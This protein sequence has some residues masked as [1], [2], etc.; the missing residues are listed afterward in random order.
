M[1]TKLPWTGTSNTNSLTRSVVSRRD[2]T[3]GGL[4]SIAATTLSKPALAQQFPSQDVH[5]ICAFPAGSGADV[6][7][8]YMA[9]KMRPLIGRSILV[10]NKPGALG[11]ISTEYL[12]RSKPDGHTILI[13]GASGVAAAASIVKNPAFDVSKAIQLVGTI[14][15][16]PTM[17]A[18]HV[19]KPWKTVGEVTAAVKEKKEKATYATTNPV[20]KVM[21]AIYKKTL[22]LQSIE[23]NYRTAADTLNDL[24]NGAIDYML[25][26]N[27]FAMSQVRENRVRV[28]AVSTG[29]RLQ[30][31][32][33]IPTMAESGIPMD[34]T[35]Y[36][37]AMVPTGTPQPVMQQIN[38]WVNEV[39]ASD[40]TKKFLN[41]FASDPWVTTS[42]QGQ[43]YFLKD[44]ENWK[45]YVKIAE[46][47]QQG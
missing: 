46:I 28:L 11:N 13:H 1:T 16:Q 31:N 41:S 19:S 8:R 26:D 5:F 39:V 34:L 44:I 14:N 12:L 43:A 33:D 38:K 21:G 37:A 15:R 30:A 29:Q 4:A 24:A 35:G 2:I 25:V 23:V 7:V 32:P 10:E 3:R 18:V 20:G 6:I 22:S 36:F 27:V 42:E 45:N 40:D 9:E 47:E 17:L